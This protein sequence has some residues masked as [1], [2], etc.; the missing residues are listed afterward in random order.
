MMPYSVVYKLNPTPGNNK[1]EKRIKSVPIS[2]IKKYGQ[3]TIAAKQFALECFSL[4]TLDYLAIYDLS[5]E[6]EVIKC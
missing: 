3:S 2:Y 4:N 1:P 6:L 5:G